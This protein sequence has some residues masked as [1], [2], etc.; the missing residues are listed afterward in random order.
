MAIKLNI[1]RMCLQ[2]KTNSWSIKAGGK[3]IL[4]ICENSGGLF[5]P[6]IIFLK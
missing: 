1:Q 4:T 6:Q 3:A 5:S 2:N